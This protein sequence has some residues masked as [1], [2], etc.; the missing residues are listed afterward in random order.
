M[1]SAVQVRPYMSAH[2]RA[3]ACRFRSGPAC[4]VQIGRYDSR[5]GGLAVEVETVLA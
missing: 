5:R 1:M 3:R 2:D 4:R